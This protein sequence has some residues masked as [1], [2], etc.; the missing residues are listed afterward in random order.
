[1]VGKGPNFDVMSPKE[2]R[3]W[4]AETGKKIPVQELILPE[5]KPMNVITTKGTAK[6]GVK[7]K[8]KRMK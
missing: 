5:P 4:E 7:A 6:T 2:R 8:K 1:M 3:Q